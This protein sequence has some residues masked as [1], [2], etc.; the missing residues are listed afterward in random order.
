MQRWKTEP[1]LDF[2]LTDPNNYKYPATK[3][4]DSL[5]DT[6]LRGYMAS[7]RVTK[8]LRRQGLVNRDGNIGCSLYDYNQYRMYL[9]EF[10]TKLIKTKRVSCQQIL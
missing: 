8:N 3:E 7:Y 6:H 9:H 5:Y 2:D 4:Y 1:I 10:Q